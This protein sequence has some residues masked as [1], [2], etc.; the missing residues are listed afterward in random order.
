MENLSQYVA[1]YG[2]QVLGAIITLVVGFWL[3]GFLA[4]LTDSSLGR[5]E[6]LDATIRHLV[7]KLVRIGVIAVTIIATLNQ[8]GVETTSLVAVLGA[9]TLAIGLALQGTLTNV[10]AGVMLLL[11]RP[12]GVGSII[13]IDGNV[14]IIDDLGLFVTRAHEPDGPTVIVPNSKIWGNTITSFTETHNDVRRI[15]ETFGIS[16]SDDMDKAIELVRGILQSHEAILDDPAPNVAI[17]KLNDSSVDIM[18]HA[19]TKRADWF[20][21]K[22]ALNKLIKETFDREGISIPFPQR[23][24]HLFQEKQSAG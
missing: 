11:L 21:T 9:A 10:A 19:W 20:P 3:A 24:I 2:L 22:L 1:Q 15:N 7:A 16:Y 5:S 14:L 13:K 17:A 18:V 6:K 12:F 4:K 23:D 8:F